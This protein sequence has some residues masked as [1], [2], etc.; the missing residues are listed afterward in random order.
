MSLLGD[1]GQGVD[2]CVYAAQR[3][4]HPQRFCRLLSQEWAGVTRIKGFI[5]LA[6]CMNIVGMW[7]WTEGNCT[8]FPAGRWWAAKPEEEWPASLAVRTMIRRSWDCKYGDRRQ[9]VV[10]IGAEM[11]RAAIFAALDALLLT[12]EEMAQGEATDWQCFADNSE[13]V[14]FGMLSQ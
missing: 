11:D 10:F 7:T 1:F 3:P 4:F 13:V 8:I 14:E 2:G 5:W 9:E 12:E 6:S